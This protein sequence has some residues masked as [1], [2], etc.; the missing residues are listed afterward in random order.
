MSDI[1]CHSGNTWKMSKFSWFSLPNPSERHRGVFVLACYLKTLTWL[2]CEVYTDSTL[3]WKE[4]G[5]GQREEFASGLQLRER[6]EEQSKLYIICHLTTLLEYRN[7]HCFSKFITLTQI[8]TQTVT[9][10]GHVP[11][12]SI[13]VPSKFWNNYKSTTLYW[14]FSRFLR[15]F[16]RFLTTYSST[17]FE[18]IES[19]YLP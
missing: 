13:I 19:V 1:T 12:Y 4:E 15:L 2:R 3:V 16:S 11:R 10:C 8:Q 6:H 17:S 14:L 5:G 18:F 9:L 7:L